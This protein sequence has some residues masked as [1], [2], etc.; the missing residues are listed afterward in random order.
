MKDPEDKI[1]YNQLVQKNRLYQF[2]A[3]VNETFD[4]ERRDLLQDPLPTAEEAY[5]CIRREIM[6]R[7]I[8]KREPSSELESSGSGGVFAINGGDRRD[9]TGKMTKGAIFNVPTVVG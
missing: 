7:G 8:M 9:L 2:L 6:R 3:G 1:I 5:A 4:K